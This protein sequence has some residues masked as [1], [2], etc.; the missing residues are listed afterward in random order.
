M[1]SLY[2]RLQF[3]R[4]NAKPLKSHLGGGG[5]GLFSASGFLTIKTPGY[6][7]QLWRD[8]HTNT[9]ACTKCSSN[10]IIFCGRTFCTIRARTVS[11]FSGRRTRSFQEPAALCDVF[12][13]ER[14]IMCNC[15]EIFLGRYHRLP[16]SSTCLPLSR[17]AFNKI[18]NWNKYI[19][20]ISHFYNNNPSKYYL[21]K[22]IR[23][24][25]MGKLQLLWTTHWW[26]II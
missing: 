3:K 24:S 15:K 25:V 17:S 6:P 22:F 2:S 1:K 13:L 21:N 14:L 18:H 10:L 26:Y 23:Q 8:P 11:G 5:G 4:G 20:E 7:P 12:R 19:L 9:S 16:A